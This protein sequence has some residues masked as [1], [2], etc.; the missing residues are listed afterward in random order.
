M[1]KLTS[2]Q[3]LFAKHYSIGKSGK[4]AA[5]LAGYSKR[6]AETIASEN[7]RKPEILQRIESILDKAG[8]SDKALA[9]RLYKAIDAGLGKKAT[10]ADAIKGIRTAL[11]LKDRF[12]SPRQ[13]V[14]ISQ[15]SQIEL[16]LQGKSV[17]ELVMSL[18]EL[19]N[20]TQHYLKKLKAE[21]QKPE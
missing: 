18:Q 2:K 20:K 11:E 13:K 16:T 17:E 12:P 5:I 19:T 21:N 6:S 15:T 9:E 7:L 10:N 1:N 8:L 14:D 3:T 4:N